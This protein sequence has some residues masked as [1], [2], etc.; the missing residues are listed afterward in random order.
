[1]NWIEQVI[2]HSPANGGL[3]T[4]HLLEPCA[5]QWPEGTWLQ[6]RRL[7]LRKEQS[8]VDAEPALQ[9]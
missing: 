7:A 4:G 5:W 2:E 9:A 3:Y 6:R 1:M 8:H